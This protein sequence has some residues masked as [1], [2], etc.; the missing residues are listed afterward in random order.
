MGVGPFDFHAKSVV[1]VHAVLDEGFRNKLNG[2]LQGGHITQPVIE[3]DIVGE[4]EA[5]GEQFPF[6]EH[7]VPGR[8][9]A[10]GIG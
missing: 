1:V 7:G 9:A 10:D 5:T 6:K 2:F 4:G 8:T 3:G